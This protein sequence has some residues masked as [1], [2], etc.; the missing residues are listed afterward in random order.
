M[1]SKTFDDPLR[2]ATVW[3]S[4]VALSWSAIQSLVKVIVSK[5][6]YLQYNQA[7]HMGPAA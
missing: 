6:L 7:Q 1:R 5:E 2:T 4:L 3:T